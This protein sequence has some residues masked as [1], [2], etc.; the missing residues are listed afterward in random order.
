MRWVMT[1][2][3]AGSVLRVIWILKDSTK[4]LA[5]NR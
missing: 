2:T 5:F 3:A 1:D 4:C